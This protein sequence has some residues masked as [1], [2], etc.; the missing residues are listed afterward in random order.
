MITLYILPLLF[1]FFLLAQLIYNWDSWWVNFFILREALQLHSSMIQLC[2]LYLRSYYKFESSFH[3][4]PLWW[5][6]LCV[7]AQSCLTL[8]D[9]MDCSPQ[10][11]SVLGIPQARILEWVAISSFRKS[12]WPRDRTWVSCDS[13]IGRW[14]LY[15]LSHMRSPRW[16]WLEPLIL[17]HCLT[18]S[19]W[20]TSK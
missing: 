7:N 4:S 15:H 16:L 8:S 17:P 20:A 12:S 6:W 19:L 18:N 2:V 5:L 13:Y 11:C 3:F 9:P 10:G 14:I 1:K